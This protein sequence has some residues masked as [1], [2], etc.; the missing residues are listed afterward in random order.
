MAVLMTGW[1]LAA[2]LAAPAEMPV[3]R[4]K[5]VFDT[6]P[7]ATPANHSVDAPLLGNGDFLAALGAGDGKSLG[8]RFYLS[9][10]DLWR[11]GRAGIGPRPLAVLR[12][13]T[14]GA[15]PATGWRTEQTLLDATTV[16][17]MPAG[18][19]TLRLRPWMA[20]KQNLLVAEMTALGGAIPVSARL[21]PA[22]NDGPVLDDNHQPFLLGGEG[23]GGGRWAWHGRIES[24]RLD[25]RALPDAELGR[26]AAREALAGAAADFALAADERLDRKSTR[27]NSSHT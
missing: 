1:L 6:P 16:T 2:A 7:S 13:T 10:N 25:A 17:T 14:E 9:K 12:I 20:A 19:R 3:A 18:E 11:L 21:E 26:L 5:A 15:T 22:G 24:V 8:A 27:L 23:Y 4:C